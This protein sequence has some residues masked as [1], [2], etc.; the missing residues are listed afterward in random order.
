VAYIAISVPVIG[1]GF[2]AERWGLRTA[3]IV[4]TLLVAALA[5]IS[6]VATVVAARR[7]AVPARG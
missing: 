2:A 7:A 4:F 3:G 6:L 1:E 5:S